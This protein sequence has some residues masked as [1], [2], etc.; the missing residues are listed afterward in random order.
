MSI[1]IIGCG[2][3]GNNIVDYLQQLN[4]PRVEYYSMNLSSKNEKEYQ[5][6]NT[7]SLDE[8][9][10]N[11]RVPFLKGILFD[12]KPCFILAGLGGKTG[13]QLVIELT[14]IAN[15]LNIKPYIIVTTPFKFESHERKSQAN[16]VIEKLQKLMCNLYIISNEDITE[17]T[18]KFKG[19]I[20]SFAAIHQKFYEIIS[21]KIVPIKYPFP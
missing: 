1:K 10:K 3:Y 8:M 20:G 2:K 9:P 4:L 19:L 6:E 14:E 7:F 13:S 17:K 12:A 21:A 15:L 5:V 18:Y 11:Y 16:L